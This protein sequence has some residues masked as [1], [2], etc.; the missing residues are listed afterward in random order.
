ME[1]IS[2]ISERLRRL[3][4]V[5]ATDDPV[6]EI[7][8]ATSLLTA[9]SKSCQSP[10]APQRHLFTMRRSTT[11]RQQRQQHAAAPNRCDPRGRA[12]V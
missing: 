11:C 2:S 5:Q 4:P 8:C 7:L 12:Y 10:H 6:K 9:I 1:V 3:L